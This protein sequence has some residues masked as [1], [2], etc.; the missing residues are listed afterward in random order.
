M[1]IAPL[2]LLGLWLTGCGGGRKVAD[3]HFEAGEYHLA[4]DEYRAIYEENATDPE[5]NFRVAYSLYQLARYAKA[6]KLFRRAAGLRQPTMQHLRLWADTRVRQ[7]LYADAAQ[8]Y[9]RILDRDKKDVSAWNNLGLMQLNLGDLPEAKRSFETALSYDAEH[10]PA[11]LNLGLLYERNER[12][13]EKAETYY[14][15]YR[16]VAPDGGQALAVREWLVDRD[17]LKAKASQRRRA[18]RAARAPEPVREPARAPVQRSAP[19]VDEPTLQEPDPVEREPVVERRAPARTRPIIRTSGGMPSVAA[20]EQM[21]ANEDYDGILASFP[22]GIDDEH[23]DYG[24]HCYFLGMAYLEKE[25]G[26]HARQF[27]EQAAKARPEDPQVA[28]QLGWALSFQGHTDRARA[29]WRRASAAHPSEAKMFRK[30]LRTV[31]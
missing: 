2:I 19:I 8:T 1:R 16:A 10:A 21:L 11:L 29:L 28:L 13:P 22:T 24:K 12:N 18:E 20:L 4:L 9:S 3:Q 7:K 27:L 23:P 26:A 15:R 31:E 25:D 30:A 17:A 5:V 6:E 14:R